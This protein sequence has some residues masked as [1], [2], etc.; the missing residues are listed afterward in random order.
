ME[1]YPMVTRTL[2]EKD[3]GTLRTPLCTVLCYE[4]SS[5][6]DFRC[7]LLPSLICHVFV[8]LESQELLC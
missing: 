5:Q 4:H 3:K 6:S 7:A 2:S 1:S 8:L